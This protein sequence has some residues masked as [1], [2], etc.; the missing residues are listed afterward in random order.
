MKDIK[1]Q[2]FGSL[3]AL[4]P[5]HQD[6]SNTWYWKY[7]CKCGA[8]HTA[9][10]NTIK[11]ELRKNDPELPS[12]GCVELARKTKHG[13]RKVKNTHPAYRVYRGI[14]SRCYDP[15]CPEYKFYGAKGVTVSAEWKN[16]PKAFVEWAI[17][18]GWSKGLV[19]DKDI[20]SDKL[21]IYPHIYSPE[22]CQWISVKDNVSYATNRNN[23]GKHP[24]VRLSHEEV[25]EILRLYNSGECTNQS[26]LARMFGLKCSSSIRR[27]IKLQNAQLE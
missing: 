27:L 2:V 15:A 22:T 25:A 26:E 1:G 4:E 18:N 8:I 16:N 7:Q 17:Q 10:A 3:T 23:Y 6:K 20:L 19:I 11:Y 14:M 5:S 13:F 21:N 24:N 12:C 9:R